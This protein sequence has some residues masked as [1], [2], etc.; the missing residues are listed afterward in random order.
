[1]PKIYDEV[2]ASA[3]KRK[4]TSATVIE[5]LLQAEVAERDARSIR[6][7]MTQAKFPVPKDLDQF[8][9]NNT[10][11]DE[12][13]IKSLYA[14]EF[15]N[16]Q[17]NIVFV[18]GTGT[19]KTHLAIA[20]ASAAIRS[21][22]RARYFNLVDLANQLEQEKL[23]GKGGRLADRL[24]RYTELV[25]L[26]ELGYLP[27]SKNGGQLIFHLLSSLYQ[28]TSVIITTN[29]AFGEWPSVFGDKKMTTALLDRVTHH[30]DIIE[31]GNESWRIKHRN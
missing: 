12:L 21:G 14:G 9:F 1:M 25:V 15:I 29:L 5:T 24:T 18:G 27:F 10:P 11:I 23:N 4:H 6:Y 7:R 31:T 17:R 3:Q 16:A 2:L 22:S 19:G 28:R 20:I 30:C 26:D 8:E 13:H